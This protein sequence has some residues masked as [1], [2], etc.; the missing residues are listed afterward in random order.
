LILKS[1]DDAGVEAVAVSVTES[2]TVE[3]LGVLH[4]IEMFQVPG[5]NAPEV[6]VPDV[7]HDVEPLLVPE[8]T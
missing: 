1:T 6:Y 3:P 8:Y 5:V 4:W 2:E 7:A